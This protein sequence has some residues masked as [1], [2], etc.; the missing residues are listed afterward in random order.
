MVAALRHQFAARWVKAASFVNPPDAPDAEPVA[1]LRLDGST[2]VL[3]S[4]Y[5]GCSYF[6][7]DWDG[8]E[9]T[10][11]AFAADAAGCDGE[12]VARTEAR[13]KGARREARSGPPSTADNGR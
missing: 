6:L 2:L 3:T 5:T 7:H 1:V 13:G 9:S 8:A 11:N 4:R 12:E 10:A